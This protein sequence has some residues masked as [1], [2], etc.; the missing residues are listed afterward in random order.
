MIRRRGER[1]DVGPPNGDG[2]G[3]GML[4]RRACAFADE[5][6]ISSILATVV[7]FDVGSSE[8]SFLS[9][10]CDVSVVSE[11]E[12]SGVASDLTDASDRVETSDR[13]LP[14]EAVDVKDSVEGVDVNVGFSGRDLGNIRAEAGGLRAGDFFKKSRYAAGGVSGVLSDSKGA[15]T[16]G[17]DTI[18]LAI[19]EGNV[20]DFGVSR[21]G[22]AGRTDVVVAM[23]ADNV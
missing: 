14:D 10:I 5:A 17:E 16:V 19:S 6:L 7:S 9:L 23:I 21:V 20:P 8:A 2:G 13:E 12:A 1:A 3:G 15:S 22:K 4:M 18:G 11:G